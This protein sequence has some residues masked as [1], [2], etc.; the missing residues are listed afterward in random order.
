MLGRSKGID[1]RGISN[2]VD[3]VMFVV[4]DVSQNTLGENSGS[5]L[6]TKLIADDNQ[7]FARGFFTSRADFLSNYVGQRVVIETLLLKIPCDFAFSSCISA[8][9]SYQHFEAY[10]T[11]IFFD[12]E[13]TGMFENKR[14]AVLGAGKLGEALIT[15]MVDAGIVSRKQF[16]ATAAHEQRLDV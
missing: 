12:L 13:G 7:A 5:I 11:M 9:K 16:I 14:I 8:S 10:D 3:D 6:L 4:F 15:G 2:R 1:L